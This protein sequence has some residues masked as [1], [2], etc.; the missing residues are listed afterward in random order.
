MS[1][2]DKIYV[3]NLDSRVDRMESI[4]SQF[5]K[6]G[7]EFTRF[8]AIKETNGVNG[9]RLSHLAILKDA[10]EQGYKKILIC[11]D[12]LALRKKFI[13]DIGGILENCL[14][15]DMLY[16]HH[17]QPS[18]IKTNVN[19]VKHQAP[20]CTHMYAVMNIDNV[21]NWVND[22]NIDMHA[23]DNIYVNSRLQTSITREEY[24][25]QL[26]DKSDISGVIEHRFKHTMYYDDLLVE[27]NRLTRYKNDIR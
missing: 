6:I 7:L 4:R 11:E 9:C 14:D 16:F 20:W 2:F 22:N 27:V 19:V 25:F 5:N 3:I 13:H 23:I 24:A 26:P 15:C 8:S 17:P 21:F 18:D 10:K 12:D 1:Y